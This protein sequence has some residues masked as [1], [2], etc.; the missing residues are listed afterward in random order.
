MGTLAPTPT[1]GLVL[2]DPG[3]AQP[4]STAVQNGWFQGIDTAIGADRARLAVIEDVTK[5]TAAGANVGVIPAGTTAERDAFWGIPGDA[6]ARVALA[7]KGAR[8][9]NTDK[10]FEQQYFAQWDDSGV[11]ANPAKKVHGWRAYMGGGG[12]IPVSKFA[13]AVIANQRKYDNLIELTAS[14]VGFQANNVFTTDFDEYELVIESL[15]SSGS[16]DFGL[17]LTTAGTVLPGTTYSRQG[18]DSNGT[19]VAAAT[20]SGVNFAN[21]FQTVSTGGALF[22]ARITNP[23]TADWKRVIA[24]GGAEGQTRQSSVVIKSNTATDG[25]R[26]ALGSG[27]LAAGSTC[28]VFGVANG[29]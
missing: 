16:T 27:T 4:F 21:I 12:R 18:L 8:W 11:A 25:F 5:P 1:L 28:R 26:I 2:P 13:T 20:Q 10:G 22:V 15:G 9:Y 7:A 29:K 3:T 23:A 24:H 17:Q 19:G 14:E 6:T